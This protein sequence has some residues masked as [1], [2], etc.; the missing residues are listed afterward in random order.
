[1]TQ[2]VREAAVTVDNVPTPDEIRTAL[3]NIL[4]N[5]EFTGSDQRRKF[6]RFVVEE[7][8]SGR[9]RDLKGVVIAHEVFRRDDDFDSKSDPVVRLE[10]RRLRRDLDS[11]YV[12][13]G[14][15]EPVRISIPKGGYVPLFENLHV[16][17][18]P[19]ETIDTLEPEVEVPP[20][21]APRRTARATLPI[22]VVQVVL[23][24]AVLG[25]LWFQWSEHATG[26]AGVAEVDLPR[27]AIP[28]FQALDPSPNTLV[29]ASG[30]SSELVHYLSQFRGLKL[31]VPPSDSVAAERLADLGKDSVPSYVVHGEVRTEGNRASVLVQLLRIGSD[32]M[33]WSDIYDLNL[34]PGS[35][36]DLHIA[37]SS[38]VASA[39]GQPYGPLAEDIRQNAASNPPANLES[40][41][42][43]LRAYSYRRAFIQTEFEPVL[44]CLEEAV[45]RNPG[46]SD[47]WAMLGW[48][49]LDGARYRFVPPERIE[50][51]YTSALAAARRAYGIDPNNVL[52]L[53]ALSAIHHHIGNY[54]ES[55]TFG[56]RAIELNPN[57]PD[58]LAQ[59]GWRLAVRGKF[60]EGVPLMDRALERTVDPPAWYYHLLSIYHLIE[61]DARQALELG[62]LSASKGSG[63]GSFLV[64]AAAGELGDSQKAR[65]GLDGIALFPSLAS[66]PSGFMRRHGATEEIVKK[67]M[68]GFVKAKRLVSGSPQAEP[69]SGRQVPYPDPVDD[70]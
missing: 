5:P 43:V 48:L 64:A 28:P 30:L 39:L 13:P 7:S 33:V 16:T 8:L 9:A 22:K 46:Y 23:G 36:I 38:E 51:E 4:A 26:T 53:K 44:D 57:D 67:T 40:Y 32:E 18:A 60:D 63:F 6:L 31:Y 66:D 42:C 3:Q 65:Q 25:I 29:L 11:F 37:V 17:P 1:M 41:L 52:T 70:L 47:A 58:T 24:I 35:L 61:G 68:S 34:S 12:G 27:V 2:E 55:E 15:A 14:R 62:E 54:E 49:R 19:A 10:A 45:T 21:P 20:N 69:A 59:V 50:I 56:W